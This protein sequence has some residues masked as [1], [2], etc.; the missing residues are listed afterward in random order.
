MTELLVRPSLHDPKGR[1]E[2]LLQ[3]TDKDRAE[4][5]KDV[6]PK[7]QRIGKVGNI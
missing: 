3:R 1:G 2:N 6:N 7:Q 5:L 4:E